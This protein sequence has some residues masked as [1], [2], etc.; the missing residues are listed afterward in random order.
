MYS[1]DGVLI[2]SAT[3]LV[4]FLECEHLLQLERKAALGHLT[5]PER[6]DDELDLVSTL[7]DEHERHHLG[8]YQAQGLRVAEIG[9][10]G[11]SPAGLRAAEQETLTAMREGADVIYQATFFDGRWLGKADF[12]LRVEE[13]SDLGAHSYEVAD[14]KLARHAKA[15]ALLQVALYSE[16]AGRLQGRLPT[17]MRLILGDDSE[18]VFPVADYISY[19]RTALGRLEAA[20]ADSPLATYPDRVEHC[21]RCRWMD[22][23]TAKRRA[24]DHL[25]I[26]AG[27]RRDQIKR[28]DEQG[29]STMKAL[30]GA[31]DGLQVPGI[32]DSPLSRIRTQARLQVKARELGGR[33]H[34]LTAERRPGIGLAALPAPSPGDIFFDMEGDPHV[35]EGGLEYLFGAMADGR[36]HSWWGHDRTEERRAFEAFVDFVM[37]RWAADPNLHIYHYASYEPDA[38]KRLVAR[39]GTREREVDDMLRGQLFVDLYRAV[40]QGV[41]ISE[42][43]YSLKSVEHFYMDA[44][45]QAVTDAGSSIVQYE[46]WRRDPDPAILR[47]LEAYN[48]ADC[49]STAM[50]RDW[51]EKLRRQAAEEGNPAPRPEAAIAAPSEALAAAAAEVAGYFKQLTEGLPDDRREWSVDDRARWLLAQSLGWHRRE[52]KSEWWEYFRRLRLTDAELVEDRD[53]IGELTFEHEVSRPKRS[54][55]LRYSFDPGQE[56]K[57]GI[58]SSPIDPRTEHS[59][60]QVVALDPEAGT[61]DIQRGADRDLPHPRSLIPQRPYSTTEQR[62]ALQ[63][64]ATAVLAGGLGAPGIQA[65][66]DLLRRT[67]PRTTDGRLDVLTMDHTTLPI[68]GPPGTGKTY[69]GAR[70]ILD[71]VAEGRR[72]GV[73]ATSHKVIG[74]LLLE[75]MRAAAERGARV[76]VMQRCNP[77]D[78]CGLQAVARAESNEEVQ[79]ALSGGE[80]DVVGATAWVWSRPEFA[81]TLSHLFVDE[82]GQMSL[83]NVLAVAGAADNL[84]LLG[85][86]QQLAQPSKGAHPPGADVS[87]LGHILGDA[88]TLPAGHGRFLETTWRMHPD[89]CRFISMA[90]YDG[91]LESEPNCAHQRVDAPGEVSGT[92]LRYF[93]ATHWGNRTSSPEEAAIV[94]RLV[95]ELVRGTWTDRDRTSRPLSLKDI[96]V[97]APFNAQVARVRAALGPEARIGTVDKFQGQEAPVVIYTLATSSPEDIPRN[98]E[99]LYSLNR[100][101]VA[102]SRAQGLAIVVCSP[103]LL[104]VRARSP[105]QM[106]LANALCLL[107]EQAQPIAFTP[108]S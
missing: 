55:V 38:L 70:M 2:L 69:T 37:A 5:R 107:V 46:S 104:K 47:D 14:T 65:A 31:P 78:H 84:V 24:D 45:D 25:S 99:F 53:A 12:L 9:D 80:V 34:V 92:G 40:Q 62:L 27:I 41:R 71:L 18:P 68:Q 85:D 67:P 96:L 94:R 39:H 100:L 64:L 49:Q 1:R 19:A 63:R 87:G 7:G 3:D 23:C 83:A 11:N 66:S 86:P 50:L 26:V 95:G 61:I 43:S 13:P 91:R 20:L 59:P 77:E 10:H 21:G 101:N 97:V 48:R 15:R 42:E 52:E 93:A 103:E 73:T 16:H 75:V 74:N 79:G 8:R 72:V 82:A 98:M 106:R 60:G 76:R 36:F 88:A 105:Q 44:R 22:V 30:A 89:V 32:G 56:H 57:I 102:V 35:A 90:S 33:F 108:V 81:G 6:A 4:G 58:G 29:I 28:L 17:H 54:V 51:L